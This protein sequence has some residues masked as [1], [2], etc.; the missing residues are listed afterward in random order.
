MNGTS[1][2][3]MRAWTGRNFFASVGALIVIAGVVLASSAVMAQG[4]PPPVKATSVP[5]ASEFKGTTQLTP[6]IPGAPTTMD[7]NTSERPLAGHT[8]AGS[9][10]AALMMALKGNIQ[11]FITIPDRQAA[12]LM[13]AG[14]NWRETVKGPIHVW[15]SWLVLGMVGVLLAFYL[16]RGRIPIEGGLSGRTIERFNGVERF[17]H[18]LTASAFVVLAVSGLNITYGRYVLLPIIGP[19]AFTV[20]TIFLKYCHNFLAFAFMAGL[21]LIFV[22]W[23]QH[24]MPNRTDVAWIA[25]GGGLFGKGVHPPAGKFNAGQKLIF[26]SVIVGGV[27]LS[28]SGIYLLFPFSF[29]DVNDQQLMQI[30][31]AVAALILTAIVIAHIYIGSI[32]ME[33]AW[34]AMGTG[35]VDENWA[36]EHHSLWVQQLRGQA[37]SRGGDD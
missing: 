24:N 5:A 27:L 14:R 7:T 9:S 4:P 15:G 36:R 18:W 19:D 33:G 26:W 11:G 30:I 10:E 28:V 3:G 22:L 37:A 31:H 17:S 29:G 25:V 2:F 35:M 20:L 23:V 6:A 32:G 12:T 21:V 34:D 16:T 13:Q 1:T 8:A